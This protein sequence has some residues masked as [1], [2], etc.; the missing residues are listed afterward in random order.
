M[1]QLWAS[2]PLNFALGATSI[3][4]LLGLIVPVTRLEREGIPAAVDAVRAT[5]QESSA[6]GLAAA[7][8]TS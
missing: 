1:K 8:G 3:G 6:N 4:V 7:N 2:D 5:L